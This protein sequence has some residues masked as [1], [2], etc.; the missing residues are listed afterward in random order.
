VCQY[1][2]TKTSACDAFSYSTTLRICN[3]LSS[4]TTTGTASGW[5]SALK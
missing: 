4:V 1:A 2:C 5:K 3:L